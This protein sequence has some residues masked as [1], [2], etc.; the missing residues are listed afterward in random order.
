MSQ[1]MFFLHLGSP[2]FISA[3]G[4]EREYVLLFQHLQ[5]LMNQDSTISSVEGSSESENRKISNIYAFIPPRQK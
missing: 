2:S 5:V 4:V 3:T 1:G